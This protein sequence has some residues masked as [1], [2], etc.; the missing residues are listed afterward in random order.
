MSGPTR[1]IQRLR[2]AL[3][4]GQQSGP[5]ERQQSP[6]GSL[7]Q[8]FFVRWEKPEQQTFPEKVW[9]ITSCASEVQM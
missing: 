4:K 1:H 7:Q 3:P 6:F 9:Q 8:G 2:V 5:I